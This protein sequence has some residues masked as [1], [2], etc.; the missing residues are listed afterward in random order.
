MKFLHNVVLYTS[1]DSIDIWFVS[2]IRQTTI[3]SVIISCYVFDGLR[4]ISISDNCLNTFQEH[5][6]TRVK[7]G[8]KLNIYHICLRPRESEILSIL[9]NRRYTKF[10]YPEHKNFLNRQQSS[11]RL[12]FVMIQSSLTFISDVTEETAWGPEP[13]KRLFKLSHRNPQFIRTSL[14]ERFNSFLCPKII[15]S[16][17]SAHRPSLSQPQAGRQRINDSHNKATTK[18]QQNQNTSNL[19]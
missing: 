1:I 10:E 8:K 12:S 7:L 11:L 16:A 18:S 14:I 15:I 9:S 19:L 13:E 17:R 3:I 4:G 6:E 5:P 2:Q